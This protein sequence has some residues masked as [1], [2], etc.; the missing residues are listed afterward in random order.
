MIHTA[1]EEQRHQTLFKPW[2][3]GDDG[4]ELPAIIGTVLT[5]LPLFLVIK[6]M[7]ENLNM[8]IRNVKTESPPKAIPC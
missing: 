5:P 7:V 1:I 8:G 2:A 3:K 4:G 6:T